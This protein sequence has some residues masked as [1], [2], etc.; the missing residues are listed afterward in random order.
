MNRRSVL[1]T[2]LFAL[3]ALGGLSPSAL[4]A[5][6]H[7][8]YGRDGWEVIQIAEYRSGVS[9]MT[10]RVRGIFV[11]TDSTIGL[12]KCQNPVCPEEKKK[13]PWKGDPIWFVRLASIKAIEYK[14]DWIRLSYETESSVESPLFALASNYGPAVDAKIRFRLK[15]LGVTIRE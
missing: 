3:V 10:R 4:R 13:D 9:G 1:R 12:F 5:Q 14:S 7:M 2:L 6:R 11:L 15:K 8:M